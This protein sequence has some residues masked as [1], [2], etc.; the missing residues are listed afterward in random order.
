MSKHIN[1]IELLD[2]T[3]RDGGY[4]NNWE[5]TDNNIVE[6]INKLV[7]SKIEIIECGYLSRTRGKPADSTC[8]LSLERINNLLKINNLDK[9]SSQFVVMVNLGEFELNDLPLFNP[10]TDLVK[11]IRLAFHKYN[12]TDA[13]K[14]ANVIKQ[15]GYDLYIQPMIID[16]Y[17]EQDILDLIKESDKLSPGAL[18]IVDSKGILRKTDFYKIVQLFNNNLN[19]CVKLGIHLHNDNNT[20]IDNAAGFVKFIKNRSIII[21]VSIDGAGRRGGN[22]KLQEMAS[23][24]NSNNNKNYLFLSFLSI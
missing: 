12:I 11:G 17:S 3:L 22:I 8:F 24:L 5:F 13:I 23:Y 1:R 20:A 15:Q 6:I 9:A 2:C 18:Y 19:S 4:L 10:D 16:S 7:K 21:D 14:A